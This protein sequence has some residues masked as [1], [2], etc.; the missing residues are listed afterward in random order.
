MCKEWCLGN[1]GKERHMVDQA[2]LQGERYYSFM[3]LMEQ[4]M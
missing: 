4:Q 2:L 3:Y 1:E